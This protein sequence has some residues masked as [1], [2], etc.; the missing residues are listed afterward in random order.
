MPTYTHI[1]SRILRKYPHIPT[2]FRAF[3]HW[4]KIYSV[5]LREFGA[6]SRIRDNYPKYVVSM[7][8]LEGEVAA[9]P[10][11]RHVNLRNFLTTDL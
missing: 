4:Y 10:G 8:P 7:E 11:I 5:H 6:L 2:Y 9:Y 1:L 3:L